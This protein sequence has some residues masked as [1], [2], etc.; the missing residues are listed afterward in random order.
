M[1]Q[2]TL[3]VDDDD[4]RDINAAIA[5]YQKTCRWHD[6]QGGVMLPEGESDLAGAIIGEICRDWLES[7]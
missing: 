7:H 3:N 2:L 4:E 6:K 1:R 5:R